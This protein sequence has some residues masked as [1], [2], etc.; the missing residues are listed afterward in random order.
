M[1]LNQKSFAQRLVVRFRRRRRRSSSRF[2][3]AR[4]G[5]HRLHVRRRQEKG[6]FNVRQRLLPEGEGAKLVAA[7]QLG[8]EFVAAGRD[9]QRREDHV[10]QGGLLGV[11]GLGAAQHFVFQ[12]ALV[13]DG[14]D[15]VL[16]DAHGEV[17]DQIGRF[18]AVR[19]KEGI[20]VRG[21]E[22]ADVLETGDFEFLRAFHDHF[23]ENNHK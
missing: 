3:L 8:H 13:V 6:L 2:S 17:G 9:A 21:E 22:R 19:G 5:R 10:H 16:R 1:T 7:L 11:G 15:A 12:L 18:V 14:E 4:L 23:S 20:P